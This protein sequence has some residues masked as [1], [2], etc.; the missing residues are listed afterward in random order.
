MRPLASWAAVPTVSAFALFFCLTTDL[1]AGGICGNGVVESSEECDPGGALHINGDPALPTCTTGS[2]CFYALSCCKF[3]CQFVGQG[4]PCAD[5]NDCTENDHCDQVGRCTGLYAPNGSA[6][7]DDLFCNGTDTCQL[8]ECVA[9]TGDPCIANT[10]CHVTCDEGSDQCAP[11][12]FVP[13]GED[14]NACTDDVCDG[15]GVCTH[16]PLPGGTI[17]RAQATACDV[18]EACAGGGAPCPEDSLV[19]NGTPCGDQC[20][21]AGTCQDGECA[22]GTP[23]QCDDDDVCNGLE[24]CDSLTGCVPGEPLDCSD[25]NGCTTDLCSPSTGCSN[26][27]LPDGSPCDDGERCSLFDSCEAGTC[28]GADVQVVALKYARFGAETV[29]S[30]NI[31]VNDEKG[32]IKF[33]R[34]GFMA[35]GSVVTAN[36]LTLARNASVDN[37][38]TNKRTGPGIVR[39]IQSTVAVPLGRSCPTPAITCGTTAV[40][41]PEKGILRLTPG[42][43]GEVKIARRGTLELDPGEYSFCSVKAFPPAAIRPRG[44]T[45]VRIAKDLKVSRAAIFEP[46]AGVAQ[47][48]VGG[49]VKLGAD[50]VVHRMAF[51]VPAGPLQLSRNAEFDGAICA[52]KLKGQK[53]VHLGCPLP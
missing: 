14:G 1:H 19:P 22:G 47:I 37:A 11:T 26:P 49:K 46:Y 8:G 39:G 23:L 21:S 42:T 44:D 40:I 28:T 48:F 33:S 7:D 10:D 2:D 25:G 13:C 4:A 6:C 51:N 38:Y 5:D 45:V 9:H 16:P 50:T 18:A 43:Y 31:A 34:A 53:G 15:G 52:D 27:V 41:V 12:P 30:G 29:G 20:T 17:C 24:T 32:L 3:N 36:T 35:D